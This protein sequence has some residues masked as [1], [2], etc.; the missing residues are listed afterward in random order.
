MTDKNFPHDVSKKVFEKAVADQN[1]ELDHDDEFT[2]HW[3]DWSIG[4]S[5][6]RVTKPYQDDPNSKA[7]YS[8]RY[9]ST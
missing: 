3:V 8:L 2:Q 5:I 7:R 4:L 1:L 9:D 6:G